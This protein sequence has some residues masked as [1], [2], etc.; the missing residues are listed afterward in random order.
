MKCPMMKD[1]LML[2]KVDG[3][4]QM[5]PSEVFK[6]CIEEECAWYD[7]HD[8]RCCVK[9]LTFDLFDC[10]NEIDMSTTC[11]NNNLIKINE[12]MKNVD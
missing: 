11:I 1:R 3:S 12:N 5:Y 2:L 4:G 6:D 10:L 8:R 9:S 7:E